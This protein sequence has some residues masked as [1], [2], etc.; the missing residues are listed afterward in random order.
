MKL[1]KND[2]FSQLYISPNTIVSKDI[3][4]KKIELIKKQ[5]DKKERQIYDETNRKKTAL[6]K[7]E[8]LEKLE[9]WKLRIK[10]A[11]KYCSSQK[12]I[13]LRNAIVNL[14]RQTQGIDI[15]E[16]DTNQAK[17]IIV[18]RKTKRD[19]DYAVTP[20][21]KLLE[22]E[23]YDL[24][25]GVRKLKDSLKHYKIILTLNWENSEWDFYSEGLD[26]HKL[27]ED[28]T[29]LQALLQSIETQNMQNF[30][31]NQHTSNLYIGKFETDETTGNYKV[32]INEKIKEACKLNKKTLG[33]GHSTEKSIDINNQ[34]LEDKNIGR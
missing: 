4:D 26:I 27:Q 30:K 16:I 14:N 29:Y 25:N 32:V 24:I 23:K 11:Y 9:E 31:D 1:K 10:K 18:M 7:V 6:Y 28:K 2:F 33:V 12:N 8:H 21:F 13:S 17:S 34:H 3:V 5:T 22:L 20:D 19:G 15:E